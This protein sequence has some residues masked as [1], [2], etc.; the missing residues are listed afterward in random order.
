MAIGL[1]PRENIRDDS[2]GGDCGAKMQGAAVALAKPNGPVRTYRMIK[3][4]R[5]V[6]LVG[7]FHQTL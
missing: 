7:V 2:G 1:L 4:V 3:A 6:P 5:A